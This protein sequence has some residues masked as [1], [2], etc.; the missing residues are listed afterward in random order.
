VD[1]RVWYVHC[2]FSTPDVF[3]VF[4][5]EKKPGVDISRFEI[6]E[7]KSNEGFFEHLIHP[8]AK[9]DS[10]ELEPADANKKYGKLP[11]QHLVQ[12]TTNFRRT[13]L[14]LAAELGKNEMF[15]HIIGQ[16]K[17]TMWRY[18][19]VQASA[20]P[21]Y[22]LDTYPSDELAGRPSALELIV[23]ISTNS[24]EDMERAKIL[25]ATPINQLIQQKWDEFGFYW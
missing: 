20:Y 3:V 23:N 5:A 13:P 21:L 15:V 6:A 14:T 22:E 16:E 17:E 25:D 18:G 19:T 8:H 11:S 7:P 2:L 24:D 9:E 4:F 1:A 12:S 10:V